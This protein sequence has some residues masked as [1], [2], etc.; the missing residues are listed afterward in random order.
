MSNPLYFLHGSSRSAADILAF[1][2]SETSIGKLETWPVA[3]KTAVSIMLA[4]NFPK[5]I[6]WG[7]DLLTI[8]N[9]AFRPIL[10]NKPAAIGRPFSDVW[11]ETWETIAP[12][13]A[14]AY[15]GEPT[16]IENFPISTNRHGYEEQAYFT[17][18]Y[19]PIR[20]ENGDIA[21]MMDTVIEVSETVAA[22]RRMAAIN[23]EL[24]HRM[25]N[26]LAMVGA[27]ASQTLR[28]ADSLAQAQT[29]LQ[30]RLTALGRAQQLLTASS[31]PQARVG[32]IVTYVWDSL[33][34]PAEQ[35]ALTGPNLWLD[36]RQTLSLALVM[37]EL[38]T[39]SVK[40]GALSSSAGKV[41]V[42][43]QM[44]GQEPDQQFSFAWREAGGPPVIEPTRRGF[45]TTLL[46]RVAPIEFHGEALLSYAP[47]GVSYELT[48]HAAALAG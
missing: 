3:L 48:T 15:A 42:S 5:A 34:V 6:V 17:F 36:D 38:V 45:G 40:Y 24:A 27:I 21:G 28:G 30:Q 19:S 18:C 26:M 23:D 10:G 31:R 20:D 14:R 44:I 2:W 25:K 8:H 1:D 46:E 11:A 13:V 4:S 32:D 16:Y 39:N 7:P 12:I 41:S 43:W 47:E 35:L 9:D 37:N 29:A 22:Q 33:S